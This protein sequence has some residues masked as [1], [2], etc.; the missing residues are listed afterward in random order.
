MARVVVPGALRQFTGGESVVEVSLAEGATLG[1]L[2]DA[3]D[4]DKPALG[5]RIRDEQGALRRYVNVYVDG[6]DVRR[7]GGLAVA[8]PGSAEVLVLPSVAGGAANSG[9]GESGERRQEAAG[10]A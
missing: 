3:L 7:A 9:P 10:L 6:E 2:L 4:A 5:R 1:D 8:V